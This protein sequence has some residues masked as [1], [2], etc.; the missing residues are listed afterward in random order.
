MEVGSSFLFSYALTHVS[1]NYY[2]EAI[3]LFSKYCCVDVLVF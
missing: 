3:I 2:F 1:E